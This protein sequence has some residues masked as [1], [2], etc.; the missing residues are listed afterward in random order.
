MVA[1][2]E[3]PGVS[4]DDMSRK[5]ANESTEPLIGH[6]GVA[7]RTHSEGMAYKPL[8]GEIAMCR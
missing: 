1:A 7:V 5:Q 4:E 3:L 6:L 2:D 8:C